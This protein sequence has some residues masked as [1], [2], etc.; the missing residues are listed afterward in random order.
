MHNR[1]A[2]E[3]PQKLHAHQTLLELVQQLLWLLASSS[4]SVSCPKR[5]WC[6]TNQLWQRSQGAKSI[7]SITMQKKMKLKITSDPA[8]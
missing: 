1:M 4:V 2:I 7:C 6:T 8:T 5:S 3:T